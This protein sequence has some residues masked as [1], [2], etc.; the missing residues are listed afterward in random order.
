MIK[1][2]LRLALHYRFEVFTCENDSLPMPYWV[3]T[4]AAKKGNS[5][6]QRTPTI[7][8]SLTPSPVIHISMFN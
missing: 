1:G 3:K 2:L 6:V 7:Q 5:A 8:E 4:A